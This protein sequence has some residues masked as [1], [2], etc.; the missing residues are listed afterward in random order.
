MKA[1]A[2]SKAS[3]FTFPKHYAANTTW[4]PDV[5]MF[6]FHHLHPASHEL[7]LQ[8]KRLTHEPSLTL[9]GLPPLPPAS[10]A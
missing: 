5:A 4:G 1:H 7:K 10:P 8:R 3:M 2:E 6:P 9:Q